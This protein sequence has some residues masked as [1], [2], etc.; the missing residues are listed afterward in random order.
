MTDFAELGD[1]FKIVNKM[2]LIWKNY[3]KYYDISSS[4]C[5]NMKMFKNDLVIHFGFMLQPA[6]FELIRHLVSRDGFALF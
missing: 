2:F 1:L 5:W 6:I 4:F 3:E